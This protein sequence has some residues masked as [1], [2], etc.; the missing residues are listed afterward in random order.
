MGLEVSDPAAELPEDDFD[1]TADE[2]LADSDP[3]V[4]LDDIVHSLARLLPDGQ[5]LRWFEAQMSAAEALTTLQRAGY[6]QAPV[7]QGGRYLG[8]FSYRSFARAVTMVG[9]SGPLADLTVSDCLEQLPFASV[10][11]KIEDI[12]DGLDKFDAVLVGSREDARG[13]ITVMDTLRYLFELANAYVLMQQIELGLRHAIRICVDGPGLA[14]C[15]ELVVAQKYKASGRE[16]PQQLGDMDLT[17][18]GSLITSRRTQ[19]RF[20]PVFGANTALVKS[21]VD[22][23]PPI[24]NDLFHFKRSLSIDDYERLATTR[25]WLFRKLENAEAP[26]ALGAV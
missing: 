14:E 16:P 10:A 25:D 9:S 18:L 13:I 26:P 1:P 11:D 3:D 19:D 20:V 23:L 2:E 12:F 22:P 17:D 5:E 21:L 24:R 8:V 7:R 15:V 6:S 4:S